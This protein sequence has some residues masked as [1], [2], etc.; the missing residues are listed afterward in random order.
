MNRFAKLSAFLENVLANPSLEDSTQLSKLQIKLEKARPH[1]LELL[2]TPPKDPK[3]R[4]QLE[5]GKW[6]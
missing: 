2:D 3:Q 4:Q 1:L 6:S 5:K